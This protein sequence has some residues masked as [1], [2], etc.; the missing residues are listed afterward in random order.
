MPKKINVM[1]ADDSSVVRRLLKDVLEKEPDIS[2]VRQAKHG[3]EAVG[4][5]P[6]CKPDVVLLDVE[7]PEMDGVEAAKKIRSL[8]ATVPIIMF[9][10]LT[11]KGGQATLD[12]L[13]SGASDCVA[14]PSGKG[15][16]NDAIRHI[17]CQLVPKIRELG[18][19]RVAR[20]NKKEAQPIFK[21]SSPLRR[22]RVDVVAVGLST[23]GPNALKEFLLELPAS[24]PFP[25]VVVQHMPPIFTNLLA[26]RLDKICKLRVREAASPVSLEPGHV[27]IAPGD[28]HLKVENNGGL[29]RIALTNDPPEHSCRPAVDVLFRSVAES[30][31]SSSLAVVMTGMGKDGL[32]GCENIKN[33]GG[34][35]LIQDEASSVVWGM[36]GSVARAGIADGMMPPKEL[37]K[38][39]LKVGQ[40]MKSQLVTK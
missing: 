20:T 24:V 22:S 33:K 17:Q 29:R 18:S 30:Y 40:P 27:W 2:V 39:I 38:E 34:T 9:S 3:R 7:M 26:E 14:K 5:F 6:A 13:A 15:H 19:R 31:G 1:L 28:R 10:S 21:K 32:A 8:D 36:P 25:I 35:I 12:A 16:V 23:G 37:G 11:D 4:F